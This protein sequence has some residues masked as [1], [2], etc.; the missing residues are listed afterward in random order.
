MSTSISAKKDS[1]EPLRVAMVHYR[2]SAI[3]GGSLRVGETIAN[4]LDSRRIA[5]EMVFAYGSAGPVTQH[6]KVPCHFLESQGPR[7]VRAWN[8]ARALFSKL[9]PDIV[10]FQD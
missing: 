5:A 1:N 10:H 4:H 9:R 3:G 8:R 6:A 7:D 2:D